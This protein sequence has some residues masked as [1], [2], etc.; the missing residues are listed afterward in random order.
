LVSAN[1]QGERVTPDPSLSTCPEAADQ[2]RAGVE[3]LRAGTPAAAATSFAAALE[4]DPG[5][6]LGYAALAAIAI[7]DALAAGFI[8]RAHDC[9]RRISR[10]ERQQVAI[11]G[12]ALEGRLTRAS[13]LGREHLSE[14]PEDALVLH[15]L[16]RHCEGLDDLLTP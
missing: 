8:V 9:A 6:A 10:R 7:D 12:L 1:R 5:F 14:F 3:Q 11:I 13:A 16:A 2:Y 15:V 4:H